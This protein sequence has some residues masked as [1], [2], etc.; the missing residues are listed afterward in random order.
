VNAARSPQ[1]LDPLGSLSSWTLAPIGGV[2][3]IGYAVLS[4]TWHLGQLADPLFAAIALGTLLAAVGVLIAWAVP[5]RA[6]FGRS[7][8]ITVLALAILAAV[9]ST[10]ATWGFDRLVQDDWGQIAFALLLACMTPLRP[11]AEIATAACAGAVLLGVVVMLPNAH[12]AITVGPA[13]YGIV[14]ATPVL[15]LGLGGA[16]YGTVMVRGTERW[17]ASARDGMA[18]L[19]PDV[20]ISAARSVQ[21][22]QVT[23]MN[24]AAAPLFAAIIERGAVSDQDIA[25]AT[26]AAAE[27]REHARRS[28]HGSWL[29]DALR[30]AGIHSMIDDPD[31]VVR[32]VDTD[33]RAALGALIAA[34]APSDTSRWPTPR[35]SAPRWPTSRWSS[36]E[37]A[38]LRQAQGPSD[39][40]PRPAVSHPVTVHITAA[41]EPQ[42]SRARLVLSARVETAPRPTARSL[43]PYVRV[44]RIVARDARMHVRQHNITVGFGYDTV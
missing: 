7:A 17:Q 36:S 43:L 22:E 10:V 32:L 44:L 42:A 1:R 20:R 15:V 40:P 24:T 2:V 35:W 18:R 16:A 38:T 12:Y 31:D 19:E 5:A 30:Q 11:P 8:F 34:L 41:A 37:R 4:T 39:T 29:D 14:A 27:L 25:Q 28:M 23:A 21:Q 3:A 33:Q 13:I 6:P 9:A 26:R